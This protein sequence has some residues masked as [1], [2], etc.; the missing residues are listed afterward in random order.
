MF[1][2]DFIY[3]F[4]RDTDIERRRHNQSEKQAP[5][6]KPDVGLYTGAWI[7]PGVEGR[8]S[9][10]EPPRLPLTYF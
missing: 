8:H 3:L 5:R 9:T 10:T 1:F 2:K 7:M 4:M 6:G